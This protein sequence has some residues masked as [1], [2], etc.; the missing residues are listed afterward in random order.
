MQNMDSTNEVALEW[1]KS[2]SLQDFIKEIV[3]ND[4]WLEMLNRPELYFS[5][6]SEKEQKRWLRQQ[7]Y[8][9]NKHRKGE[10]CKCKK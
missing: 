9:L 2:L 10:I 3:L 6:A 1:L 5:W 4:V 8:L 7:V